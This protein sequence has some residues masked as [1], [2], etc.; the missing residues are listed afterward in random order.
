MTATTSAACEGKED[1][2]AAVVAG[3]LRRAAVWSE[4]KEEERAKPGPGD[5]NATQRPGAALSHRSE[6]GSSVVDTNA[7]IAPNAEGRF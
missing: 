4:V 7:R 5:M 6:T 3:A 2:H 1:P